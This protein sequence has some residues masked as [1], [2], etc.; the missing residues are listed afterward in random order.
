MQGEPEKIQITPRRVLKGV[1]VAVVLFAAL[2]TASALWEN[3]VFIRMTPAGGFEIWALVLLSVLIGVF[4]VVRRPGC[5]GKTAGA[6][7]VLGFLGIACPVCNKILLLVFGGDLLLT[8]FEP[9][10]IYVAAFGVVIA[11]WAV[12]REIRRDGVSC[13]EPR[14]SALTPSAGS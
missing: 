4:F 7:G 8:Y 2:G 9:I 5:K 3:P 13:Q 14:E 12:L 1:A 6:G 10:R 11:G